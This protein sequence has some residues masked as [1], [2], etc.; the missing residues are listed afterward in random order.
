MD[1]ATPREIGGGQKEGDET[2][3]DEKIWAARRRWGRARAEITAL[4]PGVGAELRR[5]TGGLWL[6]MARVDKR[7]EGRL[8][9]SR[10]L[11]RGRGLTAPGSR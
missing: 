8:V 7:G 9:I 4:P 11:P 2:R 3:R 1:G 5:G 10:T 6:A